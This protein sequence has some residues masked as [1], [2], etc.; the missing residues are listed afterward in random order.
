MSY[1]GTA[2]ITSGTQDDI[3]RAILDL[4]KKINE[5]A[6]KIEELEHAAQNN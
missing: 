2:L 1:S 5:L 3:N 6:K 4:L